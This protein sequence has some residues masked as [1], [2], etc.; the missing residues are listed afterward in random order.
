MPPHPRQPR[1]AGVFLV[2]PPPQRGRQH[3]IAGKAESADLL[4]RSNVSSGG[5]W[6]K[7]FPFEFHTLTPT[8][9]RGM[10][11]RTKGMGGGGGLRI[12]AI[13]P[14]DDD[15]AYAAT[16]TGNAVGRRGRGSDTNTEPKTV[17]QQTEGH[18][19]SGRIFV[20]VC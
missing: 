20:D 5:K 13:N 11:F 10:V 3:L 7:N 18:L 9:R 17:E 19:F 8:A 1:Y 12:E 6:G 4:S 14:N 15:D 2:R 16:R